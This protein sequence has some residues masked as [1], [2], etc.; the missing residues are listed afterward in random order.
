M[1]E[2][3]EKQPT[4]DR[5]DSQ[6]EEM[7]RSL[8]TDLGTQFLGSTAQGAGLAAGAVIVSEAVGKVKDVLAPKEDGPKI[9]LPPG[10]EQ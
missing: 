2:N 9:E 7:Y 1:Q 10:T 4:E 5:H 6:T 3:E 8:G